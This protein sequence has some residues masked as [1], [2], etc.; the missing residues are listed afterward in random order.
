MKQGGFNLGNWQSNSKDSMKLIH[1][2]EAKTLSNSTNNSKLESD[3]KATIS[4]EDQSYPKTESGSTTNDNETKVFGVSW[5][6]ESD[7][8]YS[9]FSKIYEF[10]PNNVLKFLPK[11]FDLI[12]L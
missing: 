2:S 7:Q 11:L 9:D 5:D 8:F 6:P 4:E 12:Y 1:D 3:N 10:E